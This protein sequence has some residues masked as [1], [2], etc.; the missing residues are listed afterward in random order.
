MTPGEVEAVGSSVPTERREAQAAGPDD[1]LLRSVA[2]VAA[3]LLAGLGAVSTLLFVAAFEF[4]AD[5]FADPALAVAGGRGGAAILQWAALTDLFSYYLPIVPIALAIRVAIRAR[6]PLIVDVATIAALGYVIAG[7][8]GV[9]ALAAAG[10]AMMREYDAPGADQAATAVAFRLLIEVV[11]RGLWQTLD[12]ILLGF[13]FL[14]VGRLTRPRRPAWGGLAMTLGVVLWL[15]VLAGV[16][17][18]ALA[19][20]L[21]SGIVFVVGFAWAL[22]LGLLLARR[23]SF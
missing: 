1:N 16:L 8:I 22:W 11:F 20:D 19:R 14:V 4:R 2:A 3:F 12:P 21:L 15:G 10:P 5:W 17:G 7:S 13:W 6:S 23:S 18:L 9:T